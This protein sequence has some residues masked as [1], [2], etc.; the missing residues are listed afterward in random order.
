MS[1]AYI[2]YLD[3]RI[4]ELMIWRRGASDYNVQSK[5]FHV[6][7]KPVLEYNRIMLCTGPDGLTATTAGMTATQTGQTTTRR[8][9][10]AAQAG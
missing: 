4:V 3:M 5:N 10:T 2:I 9:Q 1:F 6:K 7:A 8:G